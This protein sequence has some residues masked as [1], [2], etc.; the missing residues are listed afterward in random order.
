[1]RYIYT[2]RLHLNL[3]RHSYTY[4]VGQHLRGRPTSTRCANNCGTRDA[5]TYEKHLPLRDFNNSDNAENLTRS[6]KT[7]F[8]P[9]SHFGPV[10]LQSPKKMV[11]RPFLQFNR[12]R[13]KARKIEFFPILLL[14]MKIFPLY[15]VNFLQLFQPI[16]ILR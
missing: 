13:K 8:S 14:L 2:S 10:Q 12:E 15:L 5:Y 3:T 4:E 9:F 6:E 16:G 7:F 11:I 1:L